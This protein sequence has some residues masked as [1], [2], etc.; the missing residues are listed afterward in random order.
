M[1]YL[2]KQIGA[3]IAYL[4]IHREGTRLI[5]GGEKTPIREQLTRFGAVFAAPSIY[6]DH[7]KSREWLRI[8]ALLCPKGVVCRQIGPISRAKSNSDL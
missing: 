8:S 5:Y 1:S 3:K 4:D 7:R 2:C 6:L